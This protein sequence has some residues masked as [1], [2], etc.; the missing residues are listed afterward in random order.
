[1]GSFETF[2][3]RVMSDTRHPHMRS[4]Q[5]HKIGNHP[6]HDHEMMKDE[7][8]EVTHQLRQFVRRSL[9]RNHARWRVP[10]S[11]PRLIRHR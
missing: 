11:R 6:S 7:R 5:G 3:G 9:H 2:R 10:H 8:N 4:L 1:M